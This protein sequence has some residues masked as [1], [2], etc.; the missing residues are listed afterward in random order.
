MN[1]GAAGMGSMTFIFGQVIMLSFFV[2]EHIWSLIC[3]CLEGLYFSAFDDPML[4]EGFVCVGLANTNRFYVE[5][6]L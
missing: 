2:C 6:R 5:D 3:L 1:R 4:V